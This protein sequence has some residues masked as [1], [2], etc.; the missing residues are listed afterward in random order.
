M[1][2]MFHS[3]A[4]VVVKKDV[5][6]VGDKQVLVVKEQIEVAVTLWTKNELHLSPAK[7]G[8]MASII[9]QLKEKPSV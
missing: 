3:T 6:H 7:V 9:H 8:N 4:F 5:C 1:S 2:S